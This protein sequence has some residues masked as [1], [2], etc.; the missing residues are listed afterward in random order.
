MRS[1][2]IT[3]IC[4]SPSKQIASSFRFPESHFNMLAV[5]CFWH[6]NEISRSAR[7]RAHL[8]RMTRPACEMFPGSFLPRNYN[9][10]TRKIGSSL[11]ARSALIRSREDITMFRSASE[12]HS[13]DHAVMND[14]GK[15]F[16][17]AIEQLFRRTSGLAHQRVPL[18]FLSEHSETSP[19]T[20]LT[21]LLS[22][23]STASKQ[24]VVKHRAWR[25]RRIS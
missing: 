16:A 6:R 18:K 7:D 17:S 22:Q 20:R 21:K 4:D 19:L 8:A 24:E 3:R 9:K 5:S 2:W 13:H 12:R 11:K 14:R 23:S 1:G 15:N 25:L 10:N